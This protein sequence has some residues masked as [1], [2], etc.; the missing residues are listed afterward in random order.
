MIAAPGD[1][2]VKRSARRLLGFVE[3]Q[4]H[5]EQRE[6]ELAHAVMISNSGGAFRQNVSDYVWLLEHGNLYEHYNSDDL[7]TWIAGLSEVGASDPSDTIEK[8]KKT[9]SMPWLVAA[10]IETPAGDPRAPALIEAAEKIEPDSPAFVTL[11]YHIARLLI[12]QG[13][14]EEARK[15]LD[16]LLAMR[17]QLPVST[18]NEVMA[19]RMKTARDLNELLVDAPRTPLGF[20]DS[21]DDAELPTNLEETPAPAETPAPQ[22]TA[23][24]PVAGTVE[25]TKPGYLPGHGGGSMGGGFSVEIGQS[26]AAV[27]TSAESPTPAPT[28]APRTCRGSTI[29]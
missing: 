24:I 2:T 19:L 6:Q 29:R 8:W 28:P 9:A 7:T 1:D 12:G 26:M 4:L 3:T 18:V 27:P 17:A 23:Q 16:A 20:S 14:T 11:T 25:V 21:Q 13:K 15:K 10:I 22:P 5:P